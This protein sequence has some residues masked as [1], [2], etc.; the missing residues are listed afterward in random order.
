M[1]IK[2]YLDD[3][4]EKLFINSINVLLFSII[5]YIIYKN[6][7][8]HFLINNDLIQLKGE[9]T[10]FD[11]LYYSIF[12]NFTISFGDI[13]PVSTVVRSISSL[14]LLIFWFIALY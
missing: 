10:Y 2:K 3:P 14:Q 13:I 6:N 4:H 8:S 1:A 9:L 11:F 12:L 5:Y 7:K